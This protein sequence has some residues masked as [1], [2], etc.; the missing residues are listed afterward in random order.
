VHVL[1]PGREPHQA[2]RL[3]PDVGEQRPRD[4]GE[5]VV[6]ARGPFEHPLDTIAACGADRAQS[7]KHGRTAT[8]ERHRTVT[9][10][11]LQRGGNLVK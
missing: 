11:P 10:P 3:R 6:P 9:Q 7:G 2:P 1:K 4:S 5:Q 8:D